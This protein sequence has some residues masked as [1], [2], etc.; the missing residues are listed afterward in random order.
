MNDKQR[1][2]EHS[3]RQFILHQTYAMYWQA[4]ATTGACKLRNTAQGRDPTE[5]EKAAG[6]T[7]G[8]RPHTDE[9]KVKDALDTMKRHLEHMWECQD[10]IGIAEGENNEAE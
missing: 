7:I 9:E 3:K 2:I 1:C 6:Q 8:W 5:E 10:F 4:M